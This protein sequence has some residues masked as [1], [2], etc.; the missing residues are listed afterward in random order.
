M[1][2]K[3][4]N[5]LK[6]IVTIGQMYI[7]LQLHPEQY[8]MIFNELCMTGALFYVLTIISLDICGY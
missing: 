5:R 4:I 3:Y 1:T 7:T 8:I 2:N 6:P